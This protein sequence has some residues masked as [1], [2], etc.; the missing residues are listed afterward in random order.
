MQSFTEPPRPPPPAAAE[1][2]RRPPLR[3]NHG[4]LQLLGEHVVEPGRLPG[5]QRRQLAGV[6]CARAAR[7]A[8]GRIASIALIL[9]CFA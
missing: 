8:K 5:R 6:G 7:P 3:P 4:N 9:G 1:P 2:R